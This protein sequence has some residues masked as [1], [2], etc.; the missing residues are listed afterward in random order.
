[1]H[2]A[3]T[4]TGRGPTDHKHAMQTILF[5]LEGRRRL[6]PVA[7]SSTLRARNT[8][9]SKSSYT[10]WI[11]STLTRAMDSPYDVIRARSSEARRRPRPSSQH[12]S[13]RRY[14]L[15][16]PSFQGSTRVAWVLSTLSLSL[17]TDTLIATN[18]TI[19]D[20]SCEV[21]AIKFKFKVRCRRK[22]SLLRRR[23]FLS[24]AKN[25][26]APSV[27]TSDLRRARS[28]QLLTSLF[29]APSSRILGFIEELL[30][31]LV[32]TWQFRTS[33][34]LAYGTEKLGARG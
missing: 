27:Y 12:Q 17:Y 22:T 18:R 1:M 10:H 32:S 33:V 11:L 30:S 8:C 7:K 25:S 3:R 26:V 14:R 16:R 5:I 15:V 24:P 23:L 34:S 9:T 21:L 13:I 20:W 29:S 28:V 31:G 6:V 4:S 2:R 19:G